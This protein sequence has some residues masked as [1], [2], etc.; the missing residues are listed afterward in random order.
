MR[1]PWTIGFVAAFCTTVA[2]IPQLLVVV[3]QESPGTFL[4]FSGGV[5]LWLIYGIY[6]GSR[7]VIASNRQRSD[8]R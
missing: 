1:R 7:P 5:F 2:F 4:L 3:G 8:C 6:S